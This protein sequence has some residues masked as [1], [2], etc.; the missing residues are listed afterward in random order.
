MSTP[1]QTHITSGGTEKKELVH[2]YNIFRVR[3]VNAEH[4]KTVVKDVNQLFS[5][6]VIYMPNPSGD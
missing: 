1:E 4:D 3:Q 2:T 5:S 6:N